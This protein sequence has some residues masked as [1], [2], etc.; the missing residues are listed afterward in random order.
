MSPPALLFFNIHYSG[1]IT[2]SLRT[3]GDERKYEAEY[4][5][6]GILDSLC[7]AYLKCQRFAQATRKDFF[8]LRDFV[9]FLRFLGLH[10]T[11][12]NKFELTASVLLEGLQRN[13]NGIP[14]ADFEKL[15]KDFFEKMHS[16]SWASPETVP[17]YH[18]TFV[19]LMKSRYFVSKSL[20]TLSA[21]YS[22]PSPPPLRFSLSST[23]N[24]LRIESYFLL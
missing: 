13:F 17:G 10:A 3:E 6:G 7:E 12:G 8:H 23:Q 21:L 20:P 2:K 9:Y 16:S 14:H 22:I 1:C 15:V 24:L 19:E 4:S 18:N 11:R 5:E